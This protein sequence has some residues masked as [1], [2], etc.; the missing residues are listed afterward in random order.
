MLALNIAIFGS[1]WELNS[2]LVEIHSIYV[3][4]LWMHLWRYA[5]SRQHKMQFSE[6]VYAFVLWRYV[7]VQIWRVKELFVPGIVASTIKLGMTLCYGIRRWQ[8]KVKRETYSAKMTF[9]KILNVLIIIILFLNRFTIPHVFKWKSRW[10]K[11]H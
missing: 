10:N 11:M 5:F 6:D 7:A 9:F 3:I 8:E 4:Y 1:I 2:S